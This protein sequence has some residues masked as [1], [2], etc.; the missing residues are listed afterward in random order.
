MENYINELKIRIE[1]TVAI[2]EKR[3][4]IDTLNELEKI[5]Q[6]N[7]KIKQ[8]LI[9]F[10]FDPEFYKIAKERIDNH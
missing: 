5:K 8:K 1:N 10:K 2:K 6:K 9:G 7:D 4:L 3:I